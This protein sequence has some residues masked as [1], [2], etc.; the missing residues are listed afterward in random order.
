MKKKKHY[1]STLCRIQ[2]ICEITKEHYE[3]GNQAKCYRA[4]WHKYIEPK[5]GICYRTFLNYIATPLPKESGNKFL[6]FLGHE[7]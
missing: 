1:K 4:V 2:E 5:Y 7:K 6:P 3:E